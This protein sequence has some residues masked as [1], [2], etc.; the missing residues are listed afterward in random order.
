MNKVERLN[1]LHAEWIKCRRCTLCEERTHVVFGEGNPD[2]P[3]MIIGEA[4]GETEDERGKPFVG[5]SGEVLDEFLDASALIRHEDTYITNVVG[6]RPTIKSTDDR[7]GANRLDNRPP[8]KDERDACKPRVMELIYIVDPLLI[9]T[10]GRVP[11]QVL[12]GRAPKIET[13][14]G[15]FNTLHM[16]GRHT[17]LRYA[18]ISMYHTAYLSRT[19]DRRMEG[20]WGKT[21]TDWVKICNVID[22]L[23]SAYYGI[24]R[25]NREELIRGRK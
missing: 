4:P 8:N 13:I 24:E 25:P 14:R 20:P 19:Y 9:V 17:E 2:A 23:R 6:C 7:T 5:A 12:F 16:Q 21:M 18:V 22:Y 15:R 3:I 10:I 1:A 11:F